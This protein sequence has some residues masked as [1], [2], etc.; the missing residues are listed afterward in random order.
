MGMV[1]KDVWSEKAVNFRAKGHV[2]P[3]KHH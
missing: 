1:E 3:V 2:T